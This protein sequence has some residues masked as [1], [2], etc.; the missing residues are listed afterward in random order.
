MIPEQGQKPRR[1]SAVE[2]AEIVRQQQSDG[3]NS[4]KW[5]EKVRWENIPQTRTQLG[6]AQSSRLR[7]GRRASTQEATAS[8]QREYRQAIASRNT[9]IKLTEKTHFERFIRVVCHD[10]APVAGEWRIDSQQIKAWPLCWR[11]TKMPNGVNRQYT[12]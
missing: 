8:E 10:R 6:E 4:D 12:T 9:I 7:P 11:A 2:S 1:E 5:G 3:Y